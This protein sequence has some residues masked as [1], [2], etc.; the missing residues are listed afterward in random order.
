V[1]YLEVAR[2]R[3]ELGRMSANSSSTTSS[4][5]AEQPAEGPQGFDVSTVVPW[6][7]AKCTWMLGPYCWERLAGGH[8]NLTYRVTDAAGNSFVLRRPPEGELLP[9]AH[10]MAREFK[11]MKALWDTPVPVAEPLAF[12]DD[13]SVT[14]AIFYAMRAIDGKSLYA[15]EEV[16]ALVPEGLRREHG[17]HFIDVLA[18]LHAVDPNAVG[19]G[20]LGRPDAYVARQLKRWRASWDAAKTVDA[21]D[22]ERLHEFLSNNTPEQG[23]ARLVHGDYGLHNC[24]SN[25]QGQVA[26]VIDWEISTL[27]DPLAD[28]AYAING[29]GKPGE[30][31]ARGI[32]PSQAPGYPTD[33]ELLARYAE[34]TGVDLST[35]GFY[36][37]FNH[38]KTVCIL[39]G[40]LA[41]YYAG[42]KSTEGVD[43]DGLCGARDEA[44]L[45]AV[46]AALPLGFVATLKENVA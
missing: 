38:W 43:I 11:I 1:L 7:E 31:S 33:A 44:L 10:D 35:I 15:L 20:D 40:V 16:L 37:S 12:C 34:K 26:A 21:P 24:V 32:R 30:I 18:D 39:N 4:I 9:S 27:G 23:P 45:K 6:L 13:K 41:R 5:S 22:V 42:Q 3:A 2:A 28:L 29:W 17:F 8:S 25:A 19:L 36:V 46:E 14:G